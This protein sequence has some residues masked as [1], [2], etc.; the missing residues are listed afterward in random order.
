MSEIIKNKYLDFGGLK[1]YDELINSAGQIPLGQMDELLEHCE[2]N[3][4]TIKIAD[5]NE[6]EYN[7]ICSLNCIVFSKYEEDI[8]NGIHCEM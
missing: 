7:M 1:K 5:E 4:K 3:S 2:I 8:V 6:E